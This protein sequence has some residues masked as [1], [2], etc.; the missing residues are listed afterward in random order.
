[1]KVGF[2]SADWSMTVKDAKGH[3]VWGGSGFIRLGQYADLLSHEVVVGALCWHNGIFGVRDWNGKA[4]FDCDV[5]IMQRV[6]FGDIPDKLPEA[7]ANGQIIVNDVDDWYWGLSPANGAFA[8]SHPKNNPKENTSHYKKILSGSSVVT[9][10]TPYLRDR[11]S[12]F[13]DAPI[14]LL[15]NCVRMDIYEQHKDSGSDVPVVGWVGS[16]AHRSGD[17]EILKGILG[18]LAEQGK[19]KLHHSGNVSIHPPFAERIGV[20]PELVSTL[21]M[22]APR[23]YPKLLTFD[24]GLAPLSEMPFNKAK[25]AIKLLEYSAAGIPAVVSDM[26]AYRS[27]HE[28]LGIGY[29]AKRPKNWIK[30]IEKLR[31]PEVRT[32]AGWYAREV[33]QAYDVTRGAE[34]FDSFIDALK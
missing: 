11:L 12:S 24:I 25:S 32:K 9:V 14:V 19:I 10:S 8:A 31:D 1:M 4:H 21:P 30:H 34:R 18:P 13:V 26:D 33:V 23:D 28:E 29:L 20:N 3:P 6:M 7:K 16:T 5:V 2:G 15:P 22:A 27:I 17:L